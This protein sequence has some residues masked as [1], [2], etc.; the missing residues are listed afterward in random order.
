LVVAESE[1]RPLV[2]EY[3]LRTG[4]IRWVER[5]RERQ[6]EVTLELGP[7]QATVSW[8]EAYFRGRP[9]PFAYP[10]YLADHL[11]ASPAELA[12]WR[13]LCRI[14]LGETRSYEQVAR[15][16]GLN[17]RVVGQLTGANHLAI[18]IPCHRVVGKRGGLVGYGG[19]L[20][21]KRWLL[22]HELRVTG[23]RLA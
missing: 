10:E 7:C 9:R 19:G 13:E 16:T 18:L 8:L 12:V 17:P 3:A 2:A 23:L 22:D 20:E 11:G 6:G 14:P 4:R 15:A 21:R 1:G 5:L